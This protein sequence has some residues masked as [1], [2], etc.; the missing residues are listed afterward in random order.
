MRICIL[1]LGNPLSWTR[2]Y[3]Q[4]FRQYGDVLTVGPVFDESFQITCRV[5]HMADDIPPPDIIT[6]LHSGVDLASLLPEGWRPDLIVAISDF[7]RPLC[8]AMQAFPC[9]KAYISIDTWQS[10]RDYVDA[11]QYDYVLAAQREFVPRMRATGA[12]N[13]HWL[14]LGCDPDFHHPVPAEKRYDIAFVGALTSDVHIKRAYLLGKLKERFN[15]NIQTGV[16]GEAMCRTFHE[17]RIAFNHCDINDINMR[18]FEVMAMGCPLLTNRTP[19]RTGLFD[20]FEEG[21]HMLVYDDADDLLH[22]VKQYLGDKETCMRVAKAGRDEVLAKHTYAHRV[23]RI[24]SVV[25]RHG[26][27]ATTAAMP[28]REMNGSLLDYL[29]ASPETVVDLGMTL[30]GSARRLRRVACSA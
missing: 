23:E 3:V 22:K 17:G 1:G 6:D 19:E 5:R 25:D 27:L 12:R 21:K 16:H 13:V 26:G 15:V 4:A 10:P 30:G 14:P 7:G 2:H 9:P 20:L 24:L 18:V 11:L 8:P 28:L 29:P